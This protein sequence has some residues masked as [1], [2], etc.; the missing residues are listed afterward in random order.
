MKNNAID[1]AIKMEY[2]IVGKLATTPANQQINMLAVARLCQLI[3][4]PFSIIPKFIA[5]FS[6]RLTTVNFTSSSLLAGLLSS[7][8]LSEYGSDSHQPLIKS[9]FST[10]IASQNADLSAP[11]KAIL[12]AIFD[13]DPIKTPTITDIHIPLFES[14]I[15][16]LIKDTLS[17]VEIDSRFGVTTLST[18]KIV[19]S[20]IAG[21]TVHAMRIYDISLA[22]QG[23]RALKYLNHPYGLVFQ[24][25]IEYIQHQQCPDGSFGDFETALYSIEDKQTRDNVRLTIKMEVAFQV[26]WTLFELS[27]PDICLMD[28]LFY[29]HREIYNHI[30]NGGITA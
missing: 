15:I 7:S 6:D 12:S 19:G 14:D 17:K 1:C 24:T 8:L 11:N 9:Y 20:K 22:M 26:M 30:K 2:W 4:G 18:A 25:G 28:E 23:L 13:S 3:N 21:M 10:L 29:S 5:E 16:K 27:D